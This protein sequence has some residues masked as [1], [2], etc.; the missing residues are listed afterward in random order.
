[1]RFTVQTNRMHAAIDESRSPSG[2]AEV[3]IESCGAERVQG[4]PVQQAI[5]RLLRR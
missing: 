1:M 4:N 3:S 2:E 5:E